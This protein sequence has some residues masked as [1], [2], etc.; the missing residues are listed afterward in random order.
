MTPP[1]LF[2][3]SDNERFRFCKFN[4]IVYCDRKDFEKV[5]RRAS[6]AAANVDGAVLAIPSTR[7]KFVNSE[8]FEEIMDVLGEDS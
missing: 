6:E 1:F 8:E 7:F 5:C 4:V 2:L 3:V